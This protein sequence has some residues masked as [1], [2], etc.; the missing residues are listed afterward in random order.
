MSSEPVSDKRLAELIALELEDATTNLFLEKSLG[1]SDYGC[2]AT[3]RRHADKVEALTELKSRRAQ[4]AEPPAGCNGLLHLACDIERTVCEVTKERWDEDEVTAMIELKL[5][6]W[7]ALLAECRDTIDGY[8]GLF[9]SAGALVVEEVALL[10]KL[11]AALGKGE[12]D[13]G[14]EEESSE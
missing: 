1:I 5:A 7:C 2:L 9:D 14:R 11:D 3:Q 12:A 13:G 6:P 10:A 4:Q 8:R